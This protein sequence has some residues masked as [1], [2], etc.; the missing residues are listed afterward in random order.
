M[1]TKPERK[2]PANDQISR[3]SKVFTEEQNNG[4]DN[5]SANN[6]PVK[7]YR[8]AL[9]YARHGW[10]VFPLRANDKR[11]AT[12]NG[13]KSATADPVQIGQWFER[14][15]FNVGI[16]TGNGLFVFD[17]D[18]KG[19]K[20]GQAVL[21]A[22]EAEHGKLPDTLTARTQSGGLHHYFAIPPELNLRNSTDLFS[23][24]YGGGL[25]VRCNGG[26]VVAAPSKTAN[27]YY[28]WIQKHSVATLP[29]NWITL[30]QQPERDKA[31]RQAQQRHLSRAQIER[32]IPGQISVID[33]FNETYDL[34]TILQNHRYTGQG[35]RYQSPNSNSGLA[36]VVL[37]DCEDGR[38]RCFSHHSN[39][40]LS[41]DQANDTFDVFCLLEH[42]GNHRAAMQAAG[43][44]LFTQSG[45]TVTEHNRD[46]YRFRT[47]RAA[48]NN[49]PA[50]DLNIISR[51]ARACR[52]MPDGFTVWQQWAGQPATHQLWKHLE[53]QPAFK[54][55][56][57]LH[58]AQ[59]HKE[60]A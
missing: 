21:S 59:Q 17:L 30:L 26:Y 27:G 42:G 5:K 2:N 46:V 1:H 50:S 53:Q 9:H 33:L 39:D 6:S 40:P 20:D 34:A 55:G 45:A 25:D 12:G 47:C 3:V 31:A 32:L 23:A 18:N 28:Q 11:P 7:T 60:V 24:E 38:T 4:N 43:K 48:L 52:D 41:N 36:G 51:V 58:L 8:A 49:I 16:A 22:L 19:G 14:S 54:P 37:I 13:F 44:L 29:D 56:Y 15:A 10:K 35:N 57:L